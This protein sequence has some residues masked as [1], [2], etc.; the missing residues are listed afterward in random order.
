VGT[1]IQNSIVARRTTLIGKREEGEVDS[2]RVFAIGEKKKNISVHS[3]R[4]DD[5]RKNLISQKRRGRRE[6][7]RAVVVEKGHERDEKIGRHPIRGRGKKSSFHP[8]NE[9]RKTRVHRKGERC[10]KKPRS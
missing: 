3:V 7:A 2:K 4:E 5:G 6:K 9:K 1:K 10:V 8:I